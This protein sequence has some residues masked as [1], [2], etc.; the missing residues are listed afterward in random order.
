MVRCAN[1]VPSHVELKAAAK[2]IAIRNAAIFPR[3]SQILSTER[4]HYLSGARPDHPPKN[5]PQDIWGD[6]DRRHREGNYRFT[7]VLHAFPILLP[8]NLSTQL[9]GTTQGATTSFSNT[10]ETRSCKPM[11]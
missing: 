10:I 6:Y 3:L 11:P 8:K 4:D 9:S 2:L 7:V 1:V 5:P